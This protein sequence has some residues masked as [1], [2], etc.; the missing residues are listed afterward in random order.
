MATPLTCVIT[1][2]SRGV[3]AAVARL[4]AKNG[5][6]VVINC[7]QSIDAAKIV[8][9]ECIALGASAHVVQAD[10][11]NEIDC[12]KLISQAIERY[13]GI[14]VLINNAG[15]TKFAFDHSDLDA[16]DTEDFQRIYA[17]NVIGPFNLVKF[18][19]P[20][21]MKSRA[22]SVVNVASIAGISGIGSSV[23]YAA[24]K[25]A[26]LTMTKSLARALGPI[27]VNA[28]CPGFIQGE[29]LKK[30]L[31]GEEKYEK[32]KNAIELS[33][34]LNKT[35]TAEDIAEAI[36]FL[37]CSQGI[38]T[39]ENLILDGGAHLYMKPSAGVNVAPKP[40]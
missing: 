16:L 40:K 37:A 21:L 33:N 15:T 26:L 6:N 14:D 38:I 30:G 5:H 29:W 18:A 34:P 8:Q 39:G 25:G 17:C 28:V 23:A 2:A 12:K 22:P 10:I 36:Y 32:I 19:K 27:K 13:A 20:H 7:S 1:G 3:G 11:S 24:S 4:F 35:S 9:N 31:G